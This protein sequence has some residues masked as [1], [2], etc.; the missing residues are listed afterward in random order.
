MISGTRN[1]LSAEVAR[2]TQLQRDIEKLQI[3]VSTQ[4]R[5]QTSSDDPVASVRV[6]QVRRSQGNEAAY[7]ANAETATT[8][9]T[10]VD[11]AFSSINTALDR[12]RELTV[13]SAND[14]YSPEQR[15][16]FAVELRDIAKG[17]AAT[18]VQKDPRGIDLFPTGVPTA[19]PIGDGLT[20]SGTLPRTAVFGGVATGG[21]TKDIATI[22]EEAAVAAESGDAADRTAAL[23]AV[24]D[25]SDHIIQAHSLHGLEASRIDQA[26]ESLAQSGVLLADE[27]SGIEA[28][29]IPE[30]VTLIKAKLT[31]LDAAQAIFARV[32]QKTLFDVLR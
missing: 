24:G 12:A 28:T 14:T 8:L 1:R 4:K 3:Q 20:A 21:T 26:K 5:L 19:F 17:I 32:N 22:L 30:A 18:A 31:T 11:T 13:L 29:D 23:Q 2:Q 6:S 25:A 16:A 15:Q 9:A 27:R 10:R 7:A